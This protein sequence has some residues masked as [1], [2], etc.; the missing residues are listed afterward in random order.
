MDENQKN[1]QSPKN[2]KH[3]HSSGGEEKRR[4]GDRKISRPKSKTLHGEL[5]AAVRGKLFKVHVLQRV[6]RVVLAEGRAQLKT[7]DCHV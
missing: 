7:L 3:R 4:T 2:V 6:P 5:E 1:I